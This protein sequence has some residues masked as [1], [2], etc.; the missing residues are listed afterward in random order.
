[1]GL[2]T[3]IFYSAPAERCISCR[4]ILSDRPSDRPTV[5]H[6]LVSYQNDSS[7]DHGVFTGG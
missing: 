3:V 4:S 1:V 7:Y 6:T 5:C 2:R